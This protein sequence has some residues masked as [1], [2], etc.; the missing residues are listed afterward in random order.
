MQN[1]ENSMK[2]K[3]TAIIIAIILLSSMAI[4]FNALSTVNATGLYPVPGHPTDSF[5]NATFTA[6]Q[7]GMYW[8]NMDAN[9]SAARILMWT[10][11]QDKIPTHAYIV[12]AP[13]PI[14][15]GQTCNIVMFNPQVPPGALLTN[16]VRYTYKV[17]VVKP[18]GTVQNFPTATPP[19]YSGWS[20]NSV[21]NG[22]FVSDSTGS[23]YMSYVPDQIGNYTFTVYYQQMQYLWNATMGATNDFYGTTF[24]A[25]NWTTT[26]TVQQDAVSL[27]GLTTPAYNLIPTE[28]WSRPIEQENTGWYAIASNW[29]GDTHDTFNGGNENRYQPDGTAPNTGHILWTR[30]I[31]D[32][33]VLGGSDTT[34]LGNT[35]NTGSQYQPRFLN[36]IIMYGRLYFSPNLYSSGAS[37]MMDCVDLKTGQLLWEENVTA[38]SG[39][40]ALWSSAYTT[41]LVGNPFGYYYS[42]DDPNQHGIQNPGWLFA[43]NFAV[44]FQPERGIPYL[45]IANVPGSGNNSATTWTETHDPMGAVIRFQIQNK[46]NTTNPSYYLSE[47]NSSKVI[48]ML[49]AGSDPTSNVIDA[50]TASRYDWNM[51]MPWN[52]TTAPSLKGAKL[53]DVLFGWNGTWPYGTG[54]P[55]YAYP[56]NVTVWALSLDP[57]TLGQVL[58]I[59]TISTDDTVN[60]VNNIISRVDAQDGVFVTVNVPVQSFTAYDMHTGNKLWTTDEQANT[61]TPYGYYGWASLA[62]T[63]QTKI[64]YGLFYVGGYS[65][66]VSAY[67]LT[68]GKLVWRNSIIPPGTAGNLK[69]SPA[70][71]DLIADGKLYVGTHEHSAETPLEPGNMIRALNATTGEIIWQMAGW[72]WPMSVAVADGVFIYW[73]FYDGQV[74]AIGQGPTSLTVSAPQA[75]VELGRSLVITGT[76]T[77][78]SAG[79]N[80]EVPKANH[81]SGVAAVSDDSMSQW[82]EYIYMQKAKPTNTTGVPVSLDVIDANGNQRNIGTTTSDSSGAFSFQWTPDIEGKYTVIATFA[83]SQ[84]YYGSSSETSF[85]VDPAA[86]TPPP[87]PVTSLP[88]TETYILASGIAIII[89]IAIATML[90]LRKRP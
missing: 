19:S 62:G 60:N 81:P 37:Q 48:P 54:A 22:V 2:N 14:G 55:T 59:K 26:L 31:E 89:A 75:S 45:H 69:S 23:T 76:V 46:G 80:Q 39:L 57:A 20:Q 16:G 35:F 74:Y 29:L 65:G 9:A 61:V 82:M 49:A 3:T 66:T 41:S 58:Y 36:P 6:I 4:T 32:S 51:S 64:A 40:N 7:Q 70:M 42:Q 90:I 18:D 77:D 44:G 21:Q 43:A 53:G 85:A 33:G 71:M 34:R 38:T 5:D 12:T 87:Y 72:A 10:R 73:N 88:P 63:T 1:I 27:S 13:N 50:S 25:S 24:L 67:N 84:S 56:D 28:Y 68:T 17:T 86:P 52:F 30:P 8:T 15:I 79:T 83:G 47:W 78:V 11:F